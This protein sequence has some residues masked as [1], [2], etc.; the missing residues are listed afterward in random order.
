M[1]KFI[2]N[3]KITIL[4]FT[5][6]VLLIIN[7]FSISFG[8]EDYE[9]VDFDL[10]IVTTDYL[11]LRTGPGT[12]FNSID[13]LKKDQYIRIYGKIGDW[14]IVQNDQ[15]LIGCVSLN[16]IEPCSEEKAS[17]SNV[18]VVEP[19]S[20]VD[21]NITEN[22][23]ELLSLINNERIKNGLSEL[24]IDEEI[25]N[26]ARLKAQDLVNNNYFS[27]TSPTYGTP[28]EMLKSY[29]ISYKTASEN[30]AGNTSIE[31]AISSWMNSDSHKSNILSNDYNYTGIAIVDSIAYGKIIVQFFVGR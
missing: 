2:L 16:Y 25:Q 14:Y 29:S 31:G 21:I 30:I 19:T 8:M 1:K 22:E 9:K 11:N 7:I 3:N 12:N 27:H 28:F 26:L 5:F 15:D 24:I 6:I 4:L 13:M 17:V 18:E 23:G 20:A 10:G